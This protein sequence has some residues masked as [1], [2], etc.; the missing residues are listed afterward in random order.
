LAVRTPETEAGL[1]KWA[2]PRIRR[3]GRWGIG[4]LAAAALAGLA[5]WT[6][7]IPRYKT[8]TTSPLPGTKEALQITYPDGWI[9]TDQPEKSSRVRF[10]RVSDL[11]SMYFRRR[12]PGRFQE[13]IDRN[14]RRRPAASNIEL[15][16]FLRRAASLESDERQLRANLAQLNRL[17]IKVQLDE[18]PC[19]QGQQLSY[20]V[21]GGNVPQGLYISSL[22][23][24]LPSG[25]DPQTSF[26]VVAFCTIRQGWL[27]SRRI[28]ADIMS[29]L[30]TVTVK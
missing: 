19:S 28:A 14:L 10:R 2:V 11:P 23:T 15:Y 17:G 9:A 5:I 8:V 22:A 4:L 6:A 16:V 18:T 13:W 3:P 7:V 29:R 12:Q 26:G 20:L 27:E 25:Y 30:K 24:Y 21:D 1:S